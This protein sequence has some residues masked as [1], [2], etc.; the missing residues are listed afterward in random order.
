M[1]LENKNLEVLNIHRQNVLDA[2]Y[3]C[4]CD[5]CGKMIVNI[6]TVQDIE[7]SE[8]YQIGLDC[9]KTLIDKKELDKIKLEFP[10]WESKYKIKE[11]KRMVNDQQKFLT[12]V[13]NPENTITYTSS[14][15]IVIKDNKPLKGFEEYAKGNI[16]FYESLG[17]CNKIGLEDFIKQL[18]KKNLI[19]YEGV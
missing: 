1:K 7:T 17:Y 8:K 19:K 18:T 10:D 4:M 14:R 15:D 9:K 6:A 5:N 12:L 11:F 2:E 16:L 13:G 3:V